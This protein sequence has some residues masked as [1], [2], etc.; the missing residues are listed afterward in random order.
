MILTARSCASAGTASV[1]VP[2][3]TSMVCSSCH[4]AVLGENQ[5]TR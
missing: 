4:S 3:V 5:R 1:A 2:P